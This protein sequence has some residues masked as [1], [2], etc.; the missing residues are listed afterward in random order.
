MK[1]ILAFNFFILSFALQAQVPRAICFPYSNQLKT[2]SELSCN[3]KDTIFRF[4]NGV[5]N[6]EDQA[7]DGHERILKQSNFDKIH[8][9]SAD[10]PGIILRK[11][12]IYHNQSKGFASDLA[13][14]LGGK[15][16]TTFGL[17]PEIAWIY[18]R[19]VFQGL[20]AVELRKKLYDE[21]KDGNIVDGISDFVRQQFEWNAFN[22]NVFAQNVIDVTRLK[23]LIK[24][25]INNRNKLIIV[26]HSQG[27]IIINQ[28]VNQLKSELSPS[29]LINLKK[30]VT[31]LQVASPESFNAIENGGFLVNE[32]DFARLIG[33][34]TNLSSPPDLTL[35]TNPDEYDR[36]YLRHSLIDTYLNQGYPGYRECF[37]N[38]LVDA[39]E[40][41]ES[42]CTEQCIDPETQAVYEARRHTNLNGSEGGLVSIDSIVDSTVHI[43]PLSVVCGVSTVKGEVSLWG[44]TTVINSVLD[45]RDGGVFIDGGDTPVHQIPVVPSPTINPSP[46]PNVFVRNANLEG[47][48]YLLGK[49]RVLNSKLYGK[50][51]GVYVYG[52]SS[53]NPGLP[54]PSP[55]EEDFNGWAEFNVTIDESE[56]LAS[57]GIGIDIVNS[58][59]YKGKVWDEAF[60]LSA[61]L[62]NAQ[63]KGVASIEGGEADAFS[64]EDI[65]L[66]EPELIIS[67]DSIVKG[68]VV[69]QTKTHIESSLIDKKGIVSGNAIIRS[70][71][72][73]GQVL[74]YDDAVASTQR[75]MAEV[76][77]SRLEEMGIVFNSGKMLFGALIGH[78]NNPAEMVGQSFIFDKAT[79]ANGAAFTDGAYISES[80]FVGGNKVFMT[81]TH[82][83][84]NARV[85]SDEGGGTALNSAIHESRI[86]DQAQVLG[87]PFVKQSAVF[88]NAIIKNNAQVIKSEVGS[89]F[90]LDGEF[91]FI[92]SQL[93]IPFLED[94]V[95][96]ED[97]SNPVIPTAPAP[98]SAARTI[99]SVSPAEIENDESIQSKLG[100]EKS[101]ATMCSQRIKGIREK[102]V[103]G[104]VVKKIE[105]AEASLGYQLSLKKKSNGKRLSSK[106]LEKMN[107]SFKKQ[108]SSKVMR[109]AKA[110]KK[111]IRER[112]NKFKK[113]WM[114]KKI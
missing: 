101:R 55:S 31:N 67:G 74:A 86:H 27:G 58:Y 84:G 90:V 69:T 82:V 23:N 94:P 100:R 30:W 50:S 6:D 96:E 28:A 56:V 39:A 70:S 35:P 72:V 102:S 76:V 49:V 37:S 29:Q 109:L 54:V 34:R 106:E 36:K 80:A 44:K 9:P 8:K 13:E 112:F 40:Q 25:S 99:A 1:T 65:G 16:T 110:N 51:S 83:F 20:Y 61:V 18:A 60:L 114:K 45:G 66:P 104:K 17:N 11:N 14:A 62:N 43:D 107:D 32:S 42:N 98:A 2:D 5:L 78:R 85:N 59:V 3:S 52:G 4:V 41:L 24:S 81:R 63:I 33:F 97:C 89:G 21:L 105:D 38:A 88:G 73:S 92:C 111:D 46:I 113:K 7:R 22:D 77:N 12:F 103:Y 87:S 10:Y 68:T 93:E 26:T 108:K 57:E 91:R 95:K 75:P 48:I 53:P 71:H 47:N 64:G 19:S 79:L 15:L